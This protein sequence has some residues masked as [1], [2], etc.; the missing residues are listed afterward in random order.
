MLHLHTAYYSDAKSNVTLG[1][2]PESVNDAAEISLSC[3]CGSREKL[4]GTCPRKAQHAAR[5]K[6]L[7]EGFLCFR[8][9]AGALRNNLL[10]WN[11]F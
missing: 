11:L 1:G 7:R 9:G 5:T 6:Q 3:Y 8:D 10:T 4:A 2:N